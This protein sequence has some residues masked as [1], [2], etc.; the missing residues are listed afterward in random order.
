MERM[1]FRASLVSLISGAPI[2]DSLAILR[3]EQPYLKRY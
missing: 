1:M 2:H 3:P